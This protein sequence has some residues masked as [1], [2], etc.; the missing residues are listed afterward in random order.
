MELASAP[1]NTQ[2][3]KLMSKYKNAHNSDGEWPAFRKSR[4]FIFEVPQQ[5]F[6]EWTVVSGVNNRN[7]HS[8]LAT[9]HQYIHA[10]AGSGSSASSSTAMGSGARC[11]FGCSTFSRLTAQNFNSGCLA[12]RPMAAIVR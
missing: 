5:L 1:S 8:P 9:H 4:T 12:T 3:M 2:T 10:S 7:Y 6:G 11:T